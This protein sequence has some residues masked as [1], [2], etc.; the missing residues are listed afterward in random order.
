M[1]RK[2]NVPTA[3]ETL[4]D[5][6]WAFFF[7]FP[8][9]L[10]LF[11]LLPLIALSPSRLQSPCSLSLHLAWWWRWPCLTILQLYPFPPNEQLLMAVVLGPG[12]VA[13]SGI[14]MV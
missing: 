11:P 5:V 4:F 10:S 1:R 14:V 9:F 8:A 2:K 7:V 6:S 3:Q 12:V 13:V